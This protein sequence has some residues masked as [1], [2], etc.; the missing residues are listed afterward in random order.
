MKTQFYIYMYIEVY[1]IHDYDAYAYIWKTQGTSQQCA[2][3]ILIN[4]YM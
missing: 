3:Y 2:K 4:K 1:M